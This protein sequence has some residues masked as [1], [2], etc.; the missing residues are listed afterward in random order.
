MPLMKMMM[1]AVAQVIRMVKEG[2]VLSQQGTRCALKADTICIHGDGAHALSFARHVKQ[3]LELSEITVKSY[4]LI[5]SHLG[6][7]FHWSQS[8]IQH[9]T[10]QKI[11]LSQKLTGLYC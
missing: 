1:H 10:R 7:R 4:F 5:K 8:K 2:K 6:G 11:I 9:L 3:S